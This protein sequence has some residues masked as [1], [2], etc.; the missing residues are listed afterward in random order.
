MDPRTINPLDVD[1]LSSSVQRT[2]HC[3]IAEEGHKHGGV[4]A[5]ILASIQSECFSSL[6]APIERVAALDVPIPVQT[7]LE[8]LV[9]PN[10]E[11]IV[12]AAKKVLSFS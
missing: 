12:S 7:K 5:E 9:L 6:K 2:G 10:M 4:G 1:G 3:V 8:K 11:K